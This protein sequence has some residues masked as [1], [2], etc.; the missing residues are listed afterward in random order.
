MILKVKQNE[1]PYDII[2]NY[3]EKHIPVIDDIIAV[4][5]IDGEIRNELLLVE[6]SSTSNFV[7]Q[8][9]WWEGEEDIELIDFFFV[10]DAC[11]KNNS[12]DLISRQAVLNEFCHSC[13]GWSCNP[14]TCC[15]TEWIRKLPVIQPE[16]H[17]IPVTE[18]CECDLRDNDEVLVLQKDGTINGQIRHATFYDYNGKQKFVT[19]EE[20]ITIYNVVAYMPLSEFYNGVNT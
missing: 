13:D 19:W 10:S 9:D 12:N 2:G 14:N 3:I 16:P 5:S 11:K 7:W 6:I 15:K 20:G 8:V 18:I 1:N 17:W 4:I